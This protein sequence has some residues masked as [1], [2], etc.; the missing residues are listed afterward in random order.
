MLIISVLLSE[1][2]CGRQVA[3][4]HHAGDPWASMSVHA[5]EIIVTFFLLQ[6]CIASMLRLTST[7]RPSLEELLALPLLRNVAAEYAE[8]PP[9]VKP[10]PSPALLERVS[11]TAGKLLA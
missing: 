8:R 1:Q 5:Y 2:A 6:N 3:R 7:A 4:R 11:P 9:E 10:T